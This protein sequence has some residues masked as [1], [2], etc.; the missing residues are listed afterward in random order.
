MLTWTIV[1]TKI[2]PERATGWRKGFT[3]KPPTNTWSRELSIR[4]Q[5]EARS[6][7]TVKKWWSSGQFQHKK[8]AAHIHPGCITP[9]DH[10]TPSCTLPGKNPSQWQRRSCN[11]GH[12][13]RGKVLQTGKTYQLQKALSGAH[14][15]SRWKTQDAQYQVQ[16]ASFCKEPGM[17]LVPRW[18]RLSSGA[19]DTPLDH[20]DVESKATP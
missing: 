14:G 1:N 15:K 3:D 20:Q 8:Q 17:C 5:Q 13:L 7:G 2:H 19:S 9:K 6:M 4:S 16:K 11:T 12:H 18:A 10:N